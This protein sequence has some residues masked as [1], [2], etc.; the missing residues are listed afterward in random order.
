MEPDIENMTL[1]EYREYET[2]KERRLWDN[3]RS[4]ISPTR[5][6]GV[7]FNSSHRDKS[8]TLD[9]PHYYEDALLEKYQALPILLPCFR[10]S[11]PRNE[12]GYESP[13]TS[14]KVDIDSM[15][16]AEYNLYIARQNKNPLND[17]SSSF[18][19]QFFAQ[20]PNTPNTP[21][22]KK[23]SDFDEIL[24][25]LFILGAEN[26]RRMGQDKV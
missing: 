1:D 20:P 26:L 25:D 24:D 4:K 12:H 8:V 7:E 14:N 6:K 11:L 3:V 2:E 17:H 18:T 13:N 23:D 5:Y 22:D 16:I 19:P 15:I 10:P 9:F 21:M